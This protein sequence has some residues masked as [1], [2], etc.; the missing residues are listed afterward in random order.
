MIDCRTHPKDLLAQKL[1]SPSRAVV[2][3]S[4]KSNLQ[5]V[6]DSVNSRGANG[7][8]NSRRRCVAGDLGDRRA[9][10][11]W[12]GM[13]QLAADGRRLRRH[14]ANRRSRRSTTPSAEKSVAHSRRTEHRA[15]HTRQRS[16]ARDQR[17]ERSHAE[18][19]RHSGLS[20][21]WTA[22]DR[23]PMTDARKGVT[24]YLRNYVTSNAGSVIGHPDV[25]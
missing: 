8:R 5:T 17:S 20:A 2:P 11:Q 4:Y 24:A 10:V 23:P 22:A 12:P 14:L 16:G 6:S 3:T 21:H 19:L 15:S 18:T 25:G 7:S 9:R 1:S 13:D